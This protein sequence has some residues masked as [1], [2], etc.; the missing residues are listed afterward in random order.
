LS[1]G[2]FF[3]FFLVSGFCSLVY[4][5]VWLRLAM[6]QFG[7]TTPLVS[8][9][10]SVFMAG[11]ALG[12]WGAGRI[13][14]R[15]R[16][17]PGAT[18]V[19]LYAGAE[20]VIATSAT[21]VPAV[22][23]WGRGALT[24]GGAGSWG[25]SGYYL[26]SA[27]WVTLA[28]LPFCICM[29]AT[30]PLA[31]EAIR[32]V[33]PADSARS[34]SY[35]Y[36]ANLVG[37]TAGTLASAFVLVELLGFRGTLALTAALNAVLAAAALALSLAPARA[38]E[39]LPEGAP[40]PGRAA[41]RDGLVGRR[42]VWALFATGL[43]SMAMELVWVRQLTPYLGNVVYTFATIVALYLVATFAGSRLYR[44]RTRRVDGAALP[45]SAW[46]LMAVA[47]LL[48]LL[49][50][51]PRLRIGHPSLEGLLRAA[52][53]IVP[54]CAALGF[55][56]PLLVDRWS[57]GE[58]DRAGLGYAVNVVG[59]LL[60]PLVAGFALLPLVGERWS[61]LLLALPLLVLGAVAG[62]G[63]PPAPR[64]RPAFVL[65]AAAVAGLALFAAS[66]TFESQ[67]PRSVVKRDSTA[68]VTAWGQGRN[69]SLMVNGIGMTYL[70]P[71]TKM[72]AHLP[73]AFPSEPPRR[74][75]TICFGMGTSFRSTLSWGIDAWAVE[76]VPSVPALF[77][78]FHDDGDR[79]LESPRAHVV[80]DDG[81]RFLERSGET[82]D[83]IIIDPPPP[84]E[85]AGSSLL[86]SREFYEAL[87]RRLAPRGIVQQWI[88]GGDEPV[89]AA[90]VRAFRD[91]FPYVRGF[92]SIHGWGLHMLGSQSP[93]PRESA[94]VLAARLSPDAARDLLEWGPA[95]TAQEQFEMVLR[96]EVPLEAFIAP[97]VPALRDDRPINEY[98]FLRHLRGPG[99]AAPS[100]V[101]GQPP[102][103]AAPA[104]E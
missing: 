70:S 34:F 59:C 10:L 36:V 53:A 16:G 96:Q 30:F 103:S 67:F 19:R 4:E 18:L 25:S 39:P 29:G 23:A 102:R 77:G 48:P 49:A 71:I 41:S 95:A 6:A 75:L 87:K 47:S 15:L 61:L 2:W 101:G 45:A 104:A 74:A 46:A 12:S 7:V 38:V 22:L 89:V 92:P 90:F 33:S 1:S 88:P 43:V 40:V 64:R 80:I 86:Y 57:A 73:L 83:A 62:G 32:R 52:A 94:A 50:A 9:V 78:Y 14:R 55:A 85:A 79:L 69:K 72:M 65:G 27:A 91:A 97:R 24:S 66:R 93:I 5:V 28:M 63:V 54:F 13:A 21:A 42:I 99:P 84:V 68:T 58:S 100:S 11:L 56:T 35:L 31:M 60:G 81:R 17:S 20:L 51:D 37:A 98:Y 8:I 26:A 76:L 3:V 44:Y 82:Y